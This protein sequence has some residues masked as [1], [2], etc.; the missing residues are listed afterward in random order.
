MFWRTEKG[1]SISEVE[2]LPIPDEMNRYAF[3]TVIRFSECMYI[4]AI[5]TLRQTTLEVGAGGYIHI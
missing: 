5:D 3:V 1:I 2:R 4:V